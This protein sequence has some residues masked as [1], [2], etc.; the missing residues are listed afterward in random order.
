MTSWAV[1]SDP[2]SPDAPPARSTAPDAPALPPAPA[3]PIER[4]RIWGEMIKFSH[5]I[6]ALPFA[7][8][9]AVLAG[10]HI[11]IAGQPS[12]G[13]IALIVL[14]MV[15]ARSVAMTFNRI[16]DAAIDVRNPR[17]AAR[18]L[19]AG[20][21]TLSAAYAFLMLAIVV[22]AMGC[23]GFHRFY[24]NDWPMLLGGPVLVY[25][26]FYS[27][28]K[29]FTRWSHLFLGSAIGLSPAATWL[30]IHPDSLGWTAGL[31]AAAVTCWIAGFDIIYAC[32][33]IETELGIAA[34]IVHAA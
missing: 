28:T 7:L 16:A 11:P 18:P 30:A 13:Q 2:P 14:C 15:S 17:T 33:D 22:F 3:G 10:R 20:R 32:Q 29:R 26:C 34:G 1:D 4:L 8:M 25:L 21:L 12:A 23:F 5:S 9:A 6:F 27:Y 31:L 24:A 19:P